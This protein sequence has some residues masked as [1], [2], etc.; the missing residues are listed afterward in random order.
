[1][2]TLVIRALADTTLEGD[3]HFTVRLFPAGSG[4]VIDPLNGIA[5]ITIRAD[6]A[7]LGI[8]GIEEAS[9]NIL[10][11]EPQGDYNGSAVVS[12]VRGPGVFG[13]VLVYWNI[14][15]AAISQFEE[16]SGTVTMRDRQSA[17]TITLKAL[18]DELPE[19]RREFQLTLTS[20]TSGLEISPIAKHARI[21]MAASDNPYGR[22]SF[23]QHQI[24]ASEEE[25]M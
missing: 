2:K 10:I 20:A 24:M 6:K 9:R 22:F 23:T 18:D 5:T 21:I 11:G 16:I 7:A 17:A 3:E 13:E 15:P 1:M 19:E 12:L 25:G 14:T 8:I 4:A